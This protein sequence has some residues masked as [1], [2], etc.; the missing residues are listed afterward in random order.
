[1][2]PVE[3]RFDYS[4]AFVLHKNLEE[5][6]EVMHGLSG[7]WGKHRWASFAYTGVRLRLCSILQRYKAERAFKKERGENQKRGFKGTQKMQRIS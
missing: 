5:G 3:E 1:M 7:G 2:I 6:L 4:L